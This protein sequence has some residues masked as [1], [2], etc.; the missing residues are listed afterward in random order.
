MSTEPRRAIAR[1]P[2]PPAAKLPSRRRAAVALVGARVF[3]AACGLVQV[4]L[5]AEALGPEG[6]GLWVT[7]IG[8][9]WTATLFDGGLGFAVQNRVTRLYA[10]GREAAADAVI[11]WANRRLL[12]SALAVALLGGVVAAVVPWPEWIAI[13][14]RDLATAWRNA[15]W[16]ITLAAAAVTA[17]ALPARLAAARQRLEL[18]GGYTALAAGLGL[19]ATFVAARAGASLTAFAAAGTVLA[20]LPPALTWWHVRPRSSSTG[21]APREAAGLWPEAGLFLVPQVGAAFISHLVPVLMMFFAGPLAAAAFGVLQRLYGFGLQVQTLALAPSWPAYTDAA[22]RGDASRARSLFRETLILTGLGFV[23]PLL[24]LT[25][26]VPRLLGVWLGADAPPVSVSLLAWTAAWFALQGGGQAI[27]VLLNGVGR[28]KALAATAWIGIAA[29]L[30]L[31]PWL[32][33]RHGATGVVVALLLPYAALNLP[34]TAR[35]A[36][37]ALRSI[38]PRP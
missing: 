23:L 29:T 35:E 8:A 6:L 7:L 27:A 21:A 11:A 10:D 13:E 1:P 31:S 4:R 15:V 16:V 26:W 28:L 14:D 3:A 19:L 22:A 36:V 34:L 12:V 9:L 33:S 24:A 18:T 37:R 5:V 25:P 17:L 38:G 32:A 30:A 2:D 20:V